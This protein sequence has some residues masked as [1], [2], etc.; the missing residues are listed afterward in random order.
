VGYLLEQGLPLHVCAAGLYLT[1]WVLIRP[2]QIGYETAYYWGLGGTLQAIITPNLMYAFPHIRFFQFFLTHGGIVAGVL[3]ATFV[4]KMRPGRGSILRTFILTHVLMLVA[5]A[6]NWGLGA[7]YMFLR[8]PPVGES[9]FFFLPWPWYILFLEPVGLA[10]CMI[11]YAPFWLADRA[12]RRRRSR[13]QR[14]TMR[15]LPDP[16]S[17]Q[18]GSS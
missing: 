15:P 11:L 17:A 1:A 6:A 13:T 16:R 5:G 2:S 10:F 3:V 8:E 14:A 7:N 18:G 12:R 9:L 4:M